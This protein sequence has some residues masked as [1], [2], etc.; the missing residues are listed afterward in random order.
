MR[1][2]KD[3]VFYQ[4]GVSYGRLGR[5]DFA[6]YNFGIYF[7]RLKKI[8]KAKFHFQKADELSKDGSAIKGRIHKAMEEISSKN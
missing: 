2:V 3:G 4:L 5:L 1:P 7:K 6:H 8:D